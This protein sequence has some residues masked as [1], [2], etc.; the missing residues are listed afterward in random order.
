MAT[1]KNRKATPVADRQ[2]MADHERFIDEHFHK[3]WSHATSKELEA[4]RTTHIRF[5]PAGQPFQVE[6]GEERRVTTYF[7]GRTYT[8]TSRTVKCIVDGHWTDTVECWVEFGNC[9]EPRVQTKA[10]SGG[11]LTS[12][13][14]KYEHCVPV[15]KDEDALDNLSA[16]INFITEIARESRAEVERFQS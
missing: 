6:V 15:E 10:S 11:R 13:M 4:C 3:T 8:R 7:E 12:T 1:R 14:P 16:A 9:T 2:A 5:R